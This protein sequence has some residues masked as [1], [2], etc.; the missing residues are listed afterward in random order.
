[1]SLMP[2]RLRSSLSIS[3]RSCVRFLLA[4]L[5]ER[6]ADAAS[7]VISFRRLI[8]CRMVLKL[9]SMPPS[10]RWLT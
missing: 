9:V 1:M 4:A 3:R 2:P 5:L 10:Q 7:S 6:A 8:D